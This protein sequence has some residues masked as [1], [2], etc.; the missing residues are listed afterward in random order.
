MSNTLRQTP[1][2]K[3]YLKDRS[4]VEHLL[5]PGVVSST[6]TGTTTSSQESRSSKFK[7]VTVRNLKSKTA[8]ERIQLLKESRA[9]LADVAVGLNQSPPF[10]ED[11]VGPI[12]EL[13]VLGVFVD[14]DLYPSDPP[15]YTFTTN[16]NVVKAFITANGPNKEEWSVHLA[17]M[18]NRTVDE[19]YVT[20]YQWFLL[21]IDN[22]LNGSTSTS[23][24]AN[25]SLHECFNT[26][27]LDYL[28]YLGGGTWSAMA[29]DPL[30]RI[31]IFGMAQYAD[32]FKQIG[33]RYRF[34][35]NSAALS[36]IDYS[37]TPTYSFTWNRGIVKQSYRNRQAEHELDKGALTEQGIIRSIRSHEY[38]LDCYRC[39]LPDQEDVHQEFVQASAVYV[40]NTNAPEIASQVIK[41]DYG[42]DLARLA[43]ES[44]NQSSN[45]IRPKEIP[46]TLNNYPS[47][48]SFQALNNLGVLCSNNTGSNYIYI[49][50]KTQTGNIQHGYDTRTE[51]GE[52]G[53]QYGEDYRYWWCPGKIL[54]FRLLNKGEIYR[55]S[56]TTGEQIPTG[57]TLFDRGDL[58]MRPG[59]ANAME[60]TWPAL[61]NPQT[62]FFGIYVGDLK[63]MMYYLNP[64]I[65]GHEGVYYYQSNPNFSAG[66]AR[67]NQ[68]EDNGGAAMKNTL[69]NI[70]A[71]MQGGL[72]GTT[73]V[74]SYYLGYKQ[75]SPTAW[76]SVV[77]RDPSP[78]QK[79]VRR[80]ESDLFPN[81]YWLGDY[82]DATLDNLNNL[83]IRYYN[84]LGQLTN[85]DTTGPD[86]N[87]VS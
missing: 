49:D 22:N 84:R 86:G 9:R 65:L 71:Q 4:K 61:P 64:P 57:E 1:D 72:G 82:I 2:G 32:R 25:T 60:T 36:I 59:Y 37:F 11:I 73:T 44:Y 45:I 83:T 39:V 81:G 74:D 30:D 12:D 67:V 6:S 76:D 10:P 70:F 53:F 13:T 23:F 24:L 63:W 55:V 33:Q 51:V 38:R 5:N 40:G 27:S 43:I 58:I 52:R 3:V 26:I 50:T 18:T 14:E 77:V 8:E 54:S 75:K 62:G 28:N 17:Y 31:A 47:K 85:T 41:P 69:L 46:Y 29:V 48:L 19:N 21:T 56:K 42:T 79:A 68:L 87:G 80:V 34:V 78:E 16:F 35:G 66:D 7:L 15:V 20:R